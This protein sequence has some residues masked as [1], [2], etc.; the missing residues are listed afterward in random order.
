MDCRKPSDSERT[1][2]S[3]AHH[4]CGSE[5]GQRSIE[6]FQTLTLTHVTNL[7]VLLHCT[8]LLEALDD[9]H[10]LI[11][12]DA[13]RFTPD[14]FPYSRLRRVHSLND[15]LQPRDSSASTQLAKEQPDKRTISAGLTAASSNL[16]RTS[17][18]SKAGS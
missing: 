12:H 3:F 13:Q 7:E 11:A 5:Q 18:F 9:P 15:I 1:E 2:L 16:S 4:H 10:P 14:I 17:P 6:Q 8:I